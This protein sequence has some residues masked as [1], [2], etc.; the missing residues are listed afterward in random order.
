MALSNGYH[1]RLADVFLDQAM[2][3]FPAF[4]ITGPR[5]CGK[6]TTASRH[7]AS[8]IRLDNPLERGAF[9]LSPDEVL[10]SYPTPV[11]VDEWQV[12]PEALGAVKRAVDSR[13]GE[14]GRFL[15]TGSVKSRLS[16]PGW[17]L[18]GRA[19]SVPML[20]LTRAEIEGR[21]DAGALW[22]KGVFGEA[23]PQAGRLA[24]APGLL[25]CVDFALQG[26]FP[27]AFGLPASLRRHWHSA[28]VSHLTERDVAEIAEVRSPAAF[29]K[30]LEAVSLN[31]AGLP[32][33]STLLQAASLDDRTARRYLNLLQDLRV[34]EAL[35]AWS[36]NRLARLV[37]TPKRYL[38]DSGLAAHLNHW[39]AKGLLKDGGA[40]G[41]L[42]DT[43]VLSQIRPLLPFSDEPVTA[44][45]LRDA[46]G[47]HEVDLILEAGSGQ[48]VGVEIK[49]AKSASKRDA[50]H[51]EWLR[52]KLGDRFHRG[53]V[54]HTGD[55]THRMAER[56]WAL[57][58]ASLWRP[59]MWS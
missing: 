1:L 54:L 6:T 47:D 56:V 10:G 12:A 44:C 38:L 22:L 25:E 57:P 46:N 13:R 53:I 16:A 27:E 50:R 14:P 45:H 15:V 52:D 2:A 19:V 11:L 29:R 39:E 34:A 23:A 28:Y 48:I 31:T 17:P 21:P 40:I 58:I 4:M 30:L 33:T 32:T 37:K 24:S 7:A 35:P 8:V 55:L 36:D 41:R 49:T 5:A 43:F 20:G 18:T 9:E 26:G 42:I 3:A 51:L 59:E